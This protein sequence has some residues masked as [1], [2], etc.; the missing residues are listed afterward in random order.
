[1]DEA[2]TRLKGSLTV[3]VYGPDL[4]VLQKTGLDIK[5]VLSRVPGFTELTVVGE[6][7]A[8]RDLIQRHSTSEKTC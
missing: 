1:M 7:M 5:K 3:K 2:L 8:E 4:Q 6:P